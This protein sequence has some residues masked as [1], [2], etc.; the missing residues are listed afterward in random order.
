MVMMKE[1]KC[2]TTKTAVKS[3]RECTCSE[4]EEEGLPALT[5]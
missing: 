2:E 1:I 4:R 5:L 3:F